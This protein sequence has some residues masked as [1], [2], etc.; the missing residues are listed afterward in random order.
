MFQSTNIFISLLR[1]VWQKFVFMACH[2][3]DQLK[4]Q[5]TYQV[6]LF[7]WNQTKNLDGDLLSH[8]FLLSIIL[9]NS[10]HCLTLSSVFHEHLMS[11]IFILQCCRWG[12]EY[13]DCIICEE[14][15]LPSSKWNP[16]SFGLDIKLYL[17]ANL[18]TSKSKE[19]AVQLYWHYSQFECQLKFNLQVKKIWKLFVFL[20]TECKNKKK[21]KNPKNYT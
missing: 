11:L 10:F 21:K 4:S 20:K 6:K 18:Q 15:R 16:V 3:L 5:A 13:A 12:L 19:C 1:F 2:Q 9:N 17:M 7:L 14:I 8:S